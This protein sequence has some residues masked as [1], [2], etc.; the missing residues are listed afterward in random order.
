MLD[1]SLIFNKINKNNI[2][3]DLFGGVTAAVVALPLALAFGVSS[4]AGAIAGV[5]G[6]IVVG[7]FASLFGG[8][9]AQISGPTGPMTVVMAVVITKMIADHPDTGLAMAFTVVMLAGLFQIVLGLLKLG[10]YF[11]L[12]PY[13]V[14]S[15]FMSG[16]GV[17]I[18]SLQLGPLLGLPGLSSVVESLQAL[19]QQIGNPVIP[20]LMLGIVTL[21]IVLLWPA[22]LARLLPAP[23]AALIVGTIIQVAFFADSGV[24]VIGKIPSG[25]PSLQWPVFDVNIIQ[26]MLYSA[27]LL[28]ALGAI[29]S[30]LTSLVADSM[31]H[32]YHRSD[33]ELIGQGIGN[34]FA[35]AIGALPGAGATMRTVVNIRA[36]GQSAIS[37]TTH[38]IVLL[39]IILGAGPLAEH[40]P[41]AVLA[42]ILIKVGIDIIDWGFVKKIH[43]MPISTSALMMG[44][45]LITVFDDL[46][47][48]VL[49]GAFIAN[50]V[51]IDR[52]SRIQLLGL[53]LTDGSQNEG[54]LS[55]QQQ[56]KLQ[57]MDGKVLLFQIEGA[58]SFGVARGISQR[59]S[60]FSAHNTLIIDLSKA[61]LVG[62]T[63]PMAIHDTIEKA[64]EAGD[65]VFL[66]ALNESS[67]K[68]FQQL[69]TLNLIPPDHEFSDLDS[70]LNSVS[71]SKA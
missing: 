68:S 47:N 24:A 60:E 62:M 27:A 10:K 61:E 70:A 36:G 2:K 43:R 1:K 32:D 66:V 11:T 31:T 14:I 50:L 71:I 44:V 15:G 55:N 37:G 12:V 52:L 8:T 29:D 59:L 64:K 30:L 58:M 57:S 51:T 33:K 6:A 3:G 34:F 13:A 16:I 69:G 5:Y 23:L 53:K 67:R 28:G 26:E 9:P 63:S 4:G 20:A 41:H 25:L 48:A 17:I 35:G 46:I 42:G 39:I 49:L 45:M 65:D 38:A 21:A 7:F 40:I 54:Q 22:K 19:P 18:I 56:Q